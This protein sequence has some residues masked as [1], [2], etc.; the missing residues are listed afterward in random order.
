[1]ARYDRYCGKIGILEIES[2]VML[3]YTGIITIAH[4]YAK[5]PKTTTSKEKKP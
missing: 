2:K 1:M 3:V 4:A 5:I